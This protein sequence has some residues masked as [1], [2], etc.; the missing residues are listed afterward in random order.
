MKNKQANNLYIKFWRNNIFLNLT[1]S[2]NK[3]IF[4]CSCGYIKNSQQ[5]NLISSMIYLIKLLKINANLRGNYNLN[6]ILEGAFNV[7]RIELVY[8]QLLAWQFVIVFMRLVDKI[9]H[10]GCR[11]KVKKTNLR[12]RR[13][14]G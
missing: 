10:N 6:L 9:P 2:K 3:L 8:N 13:Y 12:E 1:T 14:L 7:A 4:K 11:S 5:G